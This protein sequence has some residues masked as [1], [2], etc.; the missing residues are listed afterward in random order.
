MRARRRSA[1]IDVGIFA[2]ALGATALTL[3]YSMGPTPPG[4]GSAH[5]LHA[6]AYFVNTFAVLLAVV[7]RPGRGSGRSD[8]WTL[9]IALGMLLLG[10]VLEILQGTFFGRDAELADWVADA[11]GVALAALVFTALRRT[12]REQP[13]RRHPHPDR[14]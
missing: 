12:L 6:A 3:W 11:V 2:F 5:G 1:W 9:A 14:H 7:F 8:G 13:L 4:N 10:G